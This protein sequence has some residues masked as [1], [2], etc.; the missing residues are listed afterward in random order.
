MKN[1]RHMTAAQAYT[2]RLDELSAMLLALSN[3]VDIKL[4]EPNPDALWDEVGDISRAL[5]I[6]TELEDA[7]FGGE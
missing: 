2:V 6:A 3:A 4:N 1:V 5:E 7:V